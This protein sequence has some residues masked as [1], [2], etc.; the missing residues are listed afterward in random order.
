MTHKKMLELHDWQDASQV[1]I[2]QMEIQDDRIDLMFGTGVHVW[3]EYQ[4]GRIRVHCYRPEKD[5]PVTVELRS[6]GIEIE[7]TDYG[8]LPEGN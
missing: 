3:I 8:P 6:S 2:G 4:D 1:T 5:E 7:H